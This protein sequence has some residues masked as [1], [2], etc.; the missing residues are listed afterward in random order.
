MHACALLGEVTARPS[1]HKASIS[2][3]TWEADAV[4]STGAAA[5][6]AAWLVRD[7]SSHNKWL[8]SLPQRPPS[9]E[10]DEAYQASTMATAAR[11]AAAARADGGG[12]EGRA[13]A[14]A[15]EYEGE[16]S[17]PSVACR[18][19]TADEIAEA[20]ADDAAAR[21]R[22]ADAQSACVAGIQWKPKLAAGGAGVD[23]VVLGS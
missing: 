8:T 6:S 19:S 20:A 4:S 5:A 16:W 22:E 15:L 3:A 1:S 11:A 9:A 18:A 14:L 12:G 21:E 23:A 7:G 17:E 10:G 13:R 2:F